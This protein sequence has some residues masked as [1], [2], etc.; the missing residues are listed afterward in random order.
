MRF[1]QYRPTEN[2]RTFK[3]HVAVFI[4]FSIASKVATFYKHLH[5][6]NETLSANGS[7]KFTPTLRMDSTAELSL[8][9]VKSITSWDKILCATCLRNQLH[10]KGN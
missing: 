1:I 8:G 4:Q 3:N 5:V 9:T 10:K 6:T 2:I 7:A